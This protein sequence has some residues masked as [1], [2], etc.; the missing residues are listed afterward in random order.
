MLISPIPL[1]FLFLSVLT[2]RVC[3]S[4]QISIDLAHKGPKVKR[5]WTS[6]GLTPQDP[7]SLSNVRRQ[8]LSN[9]WL[10]NLAFIGSIPNRGVEQVRIHWLLQMVIMANKTPDFS[11]LGWSPFNGAP[12]PTAEVQLRHGTAPSLRRPLPRQIGVGTLF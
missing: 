2:S 10:T 8:M 9:D 1:C 11:F 4:L 6:T 3:S 7:C 5:F 12:A